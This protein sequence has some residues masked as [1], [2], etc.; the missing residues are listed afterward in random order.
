MGAISGGR[1][2]NVSP[3]KQPANPMPFMGRVTGI[4]ANQITNSKV[5]SILYVFKGGYVSVC[6]IMDHLVGHE[7]IIMIII[8]KNKHF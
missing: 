2:R 8:M 3:F 6:V 7:G 1:Q 5:R 4:S